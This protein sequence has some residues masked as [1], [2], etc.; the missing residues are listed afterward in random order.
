MPAGYAL[1]AATIY[2]A[3]AGAGAAGDA[4]AA[5]AAA[6]QY[7]AD[8]QKAMFD[9]QN[10]QQTG[11]RATGQ[12]ALANIGALGTG[13]YQRYDE[14]GNPVGDLQTGTGYLQH[15]FNAEDFANGMDP[16]YQFRLQQGEEATRRAANVGGGQISGN[17]LKSLNDYSQGSASTEYANAFNRFQTER[18]NIYNTLASLAGLGQT[19]LGQTGAQ[20]VQAGQNIGNAIQAGGAAQ[21][22]GIV[23]AANATTGGVQGLANQYY[24][25]NL[26]KPQAQSSGGGGGA[27]IA[28]PEFYTA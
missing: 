14:A 20:S 23:G 19:S 8:I 22:A 10:L 13:Q 4:A 17:T 26:M 27:T 24:L 3:G 12:N 7:A 5:Q 11:Y 9:K 1:A 25:S 6:S 21:A 16:S 15:R 18:G 2:S 28:A